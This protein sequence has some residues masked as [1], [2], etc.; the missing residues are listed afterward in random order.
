[1]RPLQDS[2][3]C[4]WEMQL[5]TVVPCNQG[6][7]AVVPCKEQA[8]L[9]LT[10]YA[11]RREDTLSIHGDLPQAP[12]PGAPLSV[13]GEGE[14]KAFLQHFY[15]SLSPPLIPLRPRLSAA[16][17]E[18]P[19]FISS[20]FWTHI[21]TADVLFKCKPWTKWFITYEGNF[22][23]YLAGV[24]GGQGEGRDRAGGS[25]R[26]DRRRG[27]L[28][29]IWVAHHF[30][31]PVP[32]AGGL[33]QAEEDN[34]GQVGVGDVGIWRGGGF[35][36]LTQL[37]GGWG[38]LRWCLLLR[39]PQVHRLQWAAG[40]GVGGLRARGPGGGR[41]GDVLCHARHKQEPLEKRREREKKHMRNQQPGHHTPIC[42]SAKPLLATPLQNYLNLPRSLSDTLVWSF[43]GDGVRSLEPGWAP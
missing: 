17:S 26:W 27:S 24:P 13:C 38:L 12:G 30:D 37:R 28:E 36:I 22:T 2:D 25:G 32:R 41:L 9:L 21:A 35:F 15:L 8:Q 42:F 4:L 1:M 6:P 33:L 20:F 16:L 3:V 7:E 11:Q 18:V 34:W 39:D 43:S 31:A 40:G 19:S 14:D 29:R 5:I 23:A 10:M